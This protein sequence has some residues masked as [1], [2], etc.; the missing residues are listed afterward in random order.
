MLVAVTGDDEDNLVACQVA[1]YKFNVPRT[2][3]RIRNPQNEAI[4]KKLGIDVTVSATTI[5]LEAIEKEV[6][7][8]PLT[9]LLTLSERDLEIVEVRIP[10]EST[11][12]GKLVKEISLPEGSKLALIIPKDRR[13]RIPAPS[14]LIREGDQIIAL[15]TPELEAKLRAVLT[16]I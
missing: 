5:I 13:P 4:F 14:T 10:P 7:T 2:I 16:G 12:I 8:H 1:K 11:T 15:T 9:H 6:P 3:A